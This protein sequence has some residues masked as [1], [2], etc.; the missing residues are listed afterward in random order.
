[1]PCGDT[2]AS[3]VVRSRPMSTT[4]Q[5][6]RCGKC[7]Y[8]LLDDQSLFF[9]FNIGYHE[10]C[11]E[12]E[13]CKKILV[14]GKFI[15][16]EKKA[17]CSDCG[18][19]K[20]AKKCVSCNN[21]IIG[22]VVTV[23]NGDWHPECLRC[24]ACRTVLTN[25]Q[26]IYTSNNSPICPACVQSVF[27]MVVAEPPPQ[28]A[29]PTRNSPTP[30][31][32]QSQ[33]PRASTRIQQPLT[34]SAGRSPSPSRVSQAPEL[35]IDPNIN[36]DIKRDSRMFSGR[37][38]VQCAT[39][40]PEKSTPGNINLDKRRTR[41]SIRV[42]N[43]PEK[44]KTKLPT[45]TNR[46]LREI[47]MNL[48]YT[49]A[50][51]RATNALLDFMIEQYCVEN[52]LFY[53]DVTQFEELTLGA[54]DLKLYSKTICNKYFSAGSDM[55]VNIDTQLK[56]EVYAKLANPDILMFTPAREQI[57]RLL[58]S[59]HSKFISSSQAKILLESE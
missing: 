15:D 10:N 38:S 22:K 43:V 2:N 4:G 23:L 44:R 42:S 5:K 52:L 11:F 21:I 40:V 27:N 56:E 1:V 55:E 39:V 24:T 41:C 51:F 26:K 47:L 12:C 16:V 46:P 33:Y 31:K 45:L 25:Y 3:K 53:L 37:T 29:E 13:F 54:E 50:D 49:L 30:S 8:P 32:R 36:R 19:R 58:E 6:P 14:G 20:L 59:T 17:A 18:A 34:N 48:N 9:A 28:P 7:S 35:P 57:M